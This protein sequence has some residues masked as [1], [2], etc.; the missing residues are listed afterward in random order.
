MGGFLASAVFSKPCTHRL[1]SF[2]LF[3]EPYEGVTFDN[4][5]DLKNWLNKFFDT[6][7]G[8]FWQNGINKLVERW[9]EVVNSNRENI[10]Y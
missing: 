6:R 5:E 2:L 7:P 10:I 8:D 4:E 1:L 9:K 3:V